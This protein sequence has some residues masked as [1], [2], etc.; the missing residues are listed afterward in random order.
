MSVK[1]L[2]L[3]RELD[4]ELLSEPAKQWL[5][6]NEGSYELVDNDRVRSDAWTQEIVAATVGFKIL[7]ADKEPLASFSSLGDAIAAMDG[8]KVEVKVKVELPKPSVAAVR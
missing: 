6:A 8:A 2:K 3:W 4:P 7:T 1:G 5:A